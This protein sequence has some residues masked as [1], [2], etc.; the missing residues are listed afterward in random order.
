[1]TCAS[2]RTALTVSLVVALDTAS[3]AAPSA[4][5]APSG[6]P[7]NEKKVMAVV[8]GEASNEMIREVLADGGFEW[9][10]GGVG[11]DVMTLLERERPGIV[12]VDVGIPDILGFEIAPRIKKRSD[13]KG[14]GVIL[15]ASVHDKTRYKREPESLYGADDY[16]ERHHIHDQLLPKIN[17]V[18]ESKK[19]PASTAGIADQPA[20]RSPEPPP[21]S[22]VEPRSTVSPQ[23]AKAM[24]Q[25]MSI[26]QVFENMLEEERKPAPE[27][28]A[29]QVLKAPSPQPRMVGDPAA[30]EA[31]KRLAR[32]IMSDIALYNQRAVEEGV[33]SGQIFDALR[34]EIDEGRKLYESRVPSD[35]VAST[36]YYREAID[37]FV[38]K[39]KTEM[40]KRA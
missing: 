18:L 6:S 4:P 27:K 24:E 30:H 29:S 37:D 16:I 10:P 33:R 22:A 1:M 19:Q 8:E 11:Q 21:P 34:D 9:V 20:A 14:I 17:R 32:I 26:E 35:I 28:T 31:A 12:I 38:Q 13:L 15:L 2:C 25:A 7:L 40:Q 23:K 39:R 3:A 36:D 5:S